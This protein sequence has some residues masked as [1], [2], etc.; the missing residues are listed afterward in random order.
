MTDE[1]GLQKSVSLRIGEIN[2]LKK[3]ILYLKFSCEDEGS[4]IFSSSPL[5][6]GA[7]ESLILASDLG[8][9]EVEFYQKG[10]RESERHVISRI[11][12]IEAHD[13]RVMSEN[14]KKMVYE[15]W[16]YPFRVTNDSIE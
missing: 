3:A 8:E 16:M 6:N 2:A 12:K 11:N 9:A 13:G 4:D 1:S 14:L 5:I 7:L 15:A 10:N